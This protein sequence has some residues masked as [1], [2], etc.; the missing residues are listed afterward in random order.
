MFS[1]AYL[2]VF[3]GWFLVN[4][5]RIARCWYNS[6][7]NWEFSYN[8][9]DV[10]HNCENLAPGKSKPKNQT[11]RYWLFG[12][13]VFKSFPSLNQNVKGLLFIIFRSSPGTLYQFNAVAKKK[14]FVIQIKIHYYLLSYCIVKQKENLNRQN[15]IQWGQS[16]IIHSRGN[17]M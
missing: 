9:V 7:R 14:M 17:L 12:W 2:L 10:C 15:V 8:Y 4:K 16:K 13:W 3:S 6:W 1:L 11:Y 5:L